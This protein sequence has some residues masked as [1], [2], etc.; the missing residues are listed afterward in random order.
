MGITGPDGTEE[1]SQ[2]NTA[3]ASPAATPP[4]R[5][6]A[7]QVLPTYHRDKDPIWQISQEEAMRLCNLYED[8]MGLMYPVLDIKKV[9]AYA[10]KLYRFMEAAHRSGLMQT[11]FPGADAID[12][13]DTNIL[14][15]VL[16]SA[17]SVEASGRS[18]LGRRLFEYVQP[19]VDNLLLGS[20]GVKGIRLLAMTVSLR[21]YLNQTF[22]NDRRRCS[23]SNE[24]MKALP[25]VSSDLPLVSASN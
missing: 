2:L 15:M 6:P 23:N 4:P 18:E 12:D 21:K 24:T 16:A 25:G 5:L 8:E 7:G 22:A 19:A 1:T 11:G 13:E 20:V 3:E 14:K 17:L 9:I 10:G